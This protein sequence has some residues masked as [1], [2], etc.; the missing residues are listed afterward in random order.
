[1]L[2]VISHLRLSCLTVNY[3]KV[4]LSNV[5]NDTDILFFGRLTGPLRTVHYLK[6]TKLTTAS[7]TTNE[8]A[9]NTYSHTAI[10]VHAIR[11]NHVNMVQSEVHAAMATHVTITHTNN[12]PAVLVS[13]DDM[14]LTV[15]RS[16]TTVGLGA[17][18]LSVAHQSQST[19][20]N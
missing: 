4:R 13:V 19:H 2:V 8:L 1:M 18:V 14:Y 16:V 3:A 12:V 5:L 11:H 10:R 7:N 9:D 20:N 6:Q 15:G 17:V